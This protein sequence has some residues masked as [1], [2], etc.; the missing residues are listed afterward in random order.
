MGNLCASGRP[1][2]DDGASPRGRPPQRIASPRESPRT[3]LTSPRGQTVEVNRFGEYVYEDG[4]GRYLGAEYKKQRDLARETGDKMG[5][6]AELAEKSWQQGDKQKAHEY[7]LLKT[8]M[9][10]QMEFRN[11]QAVDCVLKPQ[12]V[13]VKGRAVV[14]AGSSGAAGEKWQY[15]ANKLDCHGLYVKEAEEAAE[16]FLR[17]WKQRRGELSNDLPKEVQIVLGKGEHSDNH[18][19]KLRP[20]IKGW[21][22]RNGYHFRE[23]V[24]MSPR[25]GNVNHGAIIVPV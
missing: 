23:D 3:P 6:Y 11:K 2:K 4:G 15:R 8:K 18:R 1:A 24:V 20:A 9:R 5:Q 14:G 16:G 19:S 22:R 25:G 17:E 13:L 10:E 12:M 7:S 21:L